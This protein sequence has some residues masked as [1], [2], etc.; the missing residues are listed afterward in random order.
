MSQEIRQGLYSGIG[1]DLI[2]EMAEMEA[3]K[4]EVKL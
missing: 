3:F 1:T 2:K 4:G